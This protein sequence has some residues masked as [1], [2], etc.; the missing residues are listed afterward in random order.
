MSPA[1]MFRLRL[2]R[3]T[4][5]IALTEI[6]R[7]VEAHLTDDFSLRRVSAPLILPASSDLNDPGETV[8]F[9]LAGSDEEMEMVRG[10]DRWLR[11]QLIR[12]DIAPGF[13]VFTV[14]NALRPEVRETATQSPH[15]STWG[16]QRVVAPSSANKEYLVDLARELYQM[17]IATEEMIIEKLPH[18]SPA[19]P[20]RLHTIETAHL[21]EKYPPLTPVRREYQYLHDNPARALLI[22]SN[23]A[24][25]AESART[26]SSNK[27]T[28]D[29]SPLASA[30]IIVWNPDVKSPLCIADFTLTASTVGGNIL[31][32]PLA[33]QVLHQPRLLR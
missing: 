24:A 23:E 28:G 32:D 27:R 14:M 10:L 29:Y 4:A 7:Y 13:G 9:R 16:W 5:E 8:R 31:R 3:E 30:R 2:L 20:K 6:K 1:T 15:L 19:L 11:S 25:G 26:P 22:I 33:M 21:E 12:Y 18:L 17:L